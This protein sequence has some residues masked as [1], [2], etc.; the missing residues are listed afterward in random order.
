MCTGKLTAWWISLCRELNTANFKLSTLVNLCFGYVVLLWQNVQVCTYPKTMMWTWQTANVYWMALGKGSCLDPSWQ[1][2]K[3]HWL[4]FVS[5][6]S[7]HGSKSQKKWVSRYLKS[8]LY[9]MQWTVYCGMT[10]K[11][12]EIVAVITKNSVYYTHSQTQLYFT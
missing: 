4:F 12:L 5:G 3:A 10:A 1:K 11:G 8:C 9:P 6:L 2:H 7:Q